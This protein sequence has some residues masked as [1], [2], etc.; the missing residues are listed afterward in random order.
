MLDRISVIFAFLQQDGV[1]KLDVIRLVR[2]KN[3]MRVEEVVQEVIAGSFL[4]MSGVQ[5]RRPL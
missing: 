4:P 5:K 2:G 1:M 3:G